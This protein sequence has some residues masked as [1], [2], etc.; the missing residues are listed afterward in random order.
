MDGVDGHLIPVLATQGMGGRLGGIISRV[1]PDADET[2]GLDTDRGGMRGHGHCHD[3]VGHGLL[4]LMIGDQHPMLERLTRHGRRVTAGLGA[5]RMIA[6]LCDC[7]S[8][9]H[10]I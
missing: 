2:V 3:L 7:W 5:R 8:S 6:M 4:Y 9:A 1:G 10:K